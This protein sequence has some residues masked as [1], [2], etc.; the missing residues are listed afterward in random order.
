MYLHSQMHCRVGVTFR[1][2]PM[3]TVCVGIRLHSGM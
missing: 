1:Q 3:A 2:S